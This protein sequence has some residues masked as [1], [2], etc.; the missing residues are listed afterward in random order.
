MTE[1]EVNPGMGPEFEKFLKNDL[2]PVLK[3]AGIKELGV[4]ETAVFG[5]GGKYIVTEPIASMSQFDNPNPL[6]KSIGQDGLAAMMAKVQPLVASRRLFT[7][8]SQPDLGISPPAG[9][10]PKLGFE[11]KMSIMPGRDA[12]YLKNAKAGMDVVRKTNAKGAYAI[13][14]GL[15]ANPNEFRIAVLLDSFADMEKFGQAFMK[16]AAEAKL[17][18]MSSVVT[19]VEY[20]M[21]KYMPE[22][23]IQAPAQ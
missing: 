19:N 7:F 8:I 15:G 2:I 5:K 11:V 23:S 3:K 17:E 20:T 22:L 10:V 21:Y 9:Y 1:I 13:R 4:W 6:V 16:A 14:L 18:P 12:D